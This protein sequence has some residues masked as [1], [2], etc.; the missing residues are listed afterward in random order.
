MSNAIANVSLFYTFFCQ[1]TLQIASNLLDERHKEQ[2]SELQKVITKQYV[3]AYWQNLALSLI[4]LLPP[5]H[6]HS[7]IY[8]RLKDTPPITKMQKIWFI[9]SFKEIEGTKKCGPSPHAIWTL[10]FSSKPEMT[11]KWRTQTRDSAT[12]QEP[13][14][15]RMFWRVQ[16]RFCSRYF[17]KKFIVAL[18]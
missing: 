12:L 1:P 14:T 18:R 7:Y 4:N 17:T 10:R 2:W 8:R 9:T 3:S 16:K 13:I 5:L 11:Q 15:K 6:S